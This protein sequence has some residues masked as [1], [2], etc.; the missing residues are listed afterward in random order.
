MMWGILYRAI[1]TFSW[2][3]CVGFTQAA[4]RI[5]KVDPLIG[6]TI[7][8][9]GSFFIMGSPLKDGLRPSGTWRPA[10]LRIITVLITDLRPPSAETLNP[11]TLNP[12][13]P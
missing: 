10:G 7:L 6:D 13:E 11:K 3:V 1:N 2:G 4:R 9:K 5:Q 12:C 8:P